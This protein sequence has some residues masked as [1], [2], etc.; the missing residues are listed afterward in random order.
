M[1][2]LNNNLCF[3]SNIYS[4]ATK[5]ELGDGQKDEKSVPSYWFMLLVCFLGVGV[6]VALGLGLSMGHPDPILAPH[7][8]MQGAVSSDHKLCSEVGR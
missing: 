1:D 6:F 5:R 2:V 8:F 4:E 7:Q 3:L